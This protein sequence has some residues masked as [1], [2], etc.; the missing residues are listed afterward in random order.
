MLFLPLEE[1]GQ[2]TTALQISSPLKNTQ[3]QVN[4]GSKQLLHLAS[5]LK[6]KSS[7]VYLRCI[8]SATKATCA[9]RTLTCG[10][11]FSQCA[12]AQEASKMTLGSEDSPNDELRASKTPSGR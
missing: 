5:A 6:V 10:G 4:F 8:A 2:Q 9:G 11:I 7:V 3:K 12:S 1:Q